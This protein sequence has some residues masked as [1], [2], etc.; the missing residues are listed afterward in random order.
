MADL[1]RPSRDGDQFHYLWAARRCLALLLATTDLVGIRVEGASADEPR[2][3]S[4]TLAADAAIDIAQYYG[5]TESGRAQRVRYFA[6]QA[7]DTLSRQRLD[8]HGSE[9]D[10]E[11]FAEKYGA[12]LQ[13]SQRQ[14]RALLADRPA[15][16]GSFEGALGLNPPRLAGGCSA[17]AHLGGSSEPREAP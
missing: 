6:P 11:A 2:S 10:L 9:D 5:D 3:G 16:P 14:L 1:I 13:Q 7:L 15:R 4:S 17:G 12:V 8:G